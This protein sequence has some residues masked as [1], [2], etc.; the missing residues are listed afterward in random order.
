[1]TT[2]FTGGLKMGG[3]AKK[4]EEVRKDFPFFV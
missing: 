4:K 1:M 3:I 2:N